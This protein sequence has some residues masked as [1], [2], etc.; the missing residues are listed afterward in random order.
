VFVNPNAL[1]DARVL[2]GIAEELGKPLGFRTSAEA[3]D[4]MVEMGPWDGDRAALPE[5]PE[6]LSG[7]REGQVALAS[8][9][10]MLDNGSMQDGEKNLRATARTPVCRVS[11]AAASA[12]GAMVTLQGDRGSVTLPIEVADDLPDGVVWV[13][14]NS[15]GN[16]VLADLASPGSGVHLKGG[17]R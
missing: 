12:L 4:R 10:L 5:T 16:G 1:P 7:L 3:H 17:D 13:P 6:S 11:R 15:T 9:K 14:A 2:A 8:W